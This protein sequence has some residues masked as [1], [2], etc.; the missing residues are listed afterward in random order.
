MRLVSHGTTCYAT[1]DVC[2]PR[3]SDHFL[4][5]KT[6]KTH[7]E[8]TVR[9][10]SPLPHHRTSTS[11]FLLRSSITRTFLLLFICRRLWHTGDPKKSTRPVTV[12]ARFGGTAFFAG[13]VPERTKDVSQVI[14]GEKIRLI[15]VGQKHCC[16]ISTGSTTRWFSC[17]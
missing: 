10:C 1:E 12:G 8:R 11:I 14:H 3:D 9:N 2:E 6:A 4:T 7:R 17:T 16:T 13:V 5:S 15:S